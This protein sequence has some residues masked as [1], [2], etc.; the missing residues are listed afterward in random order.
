MLKYISAILLAI[1]LGGCWP[2]DGS[3]VPL[4]QNEYTMVNVP[5]S[6]YNCPQ[7]KDLPNPAT[8]TD[9]DVAKLLVR[10]HT[11]NETCGESLEQIRQYLAE[12]RVRL[13]LKK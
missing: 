13:S 6:L 12:A 1:S 4:V 9:L 7:I 5:D 2:F 11:D 3:T 8:L 10:L